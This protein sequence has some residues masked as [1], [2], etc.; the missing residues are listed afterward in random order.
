MTV[1]ELIDQLKEYNPE[2]E[3]FVD[4]RHVEIQIDDCSGLYDTA[5]VNLST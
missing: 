1:Q 3:V 4:C 2:A 5:H